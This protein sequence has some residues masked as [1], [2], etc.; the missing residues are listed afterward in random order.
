[1]MSACAHIVRGPRTSASGITASAGVVTPCLTAWS[2]VYQIPKVPPATEPKPTTSATIAAA[3]S[4]PL[5][6][7]G[8]VCS[9][10]VTRSVTV[11]AIASSLSFRPTAYARDYRGMPFQRREANVTRPRDKDPSPPGTKAPH[12]SGR[13]GA[14]AGETQGEVGHPQGHEEGHDRLCSGQGGD[15]GEVGGGEGDRR[16]AG[17][18]AELR[19]QRRP[20]QDRHQIGERPEEHLADSRHHRHQGG[21]TEGGGRNTPQETE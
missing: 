15:G 8:E 6:F 5:F 12:G 4:R 10:G 7:M 11:A 2:H 3:S 19:L 17:H 20:G 21:C 1:M 16:A 14:E 18:A 13:N 9:V